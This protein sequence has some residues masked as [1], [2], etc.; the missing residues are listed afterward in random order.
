MSFETSGVQLLWVR[1]LAKLTLCLDFY[2]WLPAYFARA[3]N[4]KR[5]QVVAPADVFI[6]SSETVVGQSSLYAHCENSGDHGGTCR[7]V[8]DLIEQKP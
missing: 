8:S 5:L 7:P 6:V 3:A 1:R 2:F 4:P